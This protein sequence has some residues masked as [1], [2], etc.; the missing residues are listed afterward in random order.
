MWNRYEMLSHMWRCRQ[1]GMPI[2]NYGLMI[3]YTLGVFDRTLEP[4]P[5]AM[6]TYRRLQAK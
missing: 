5:D 4:F 2:C 3:A 6:E 1:A